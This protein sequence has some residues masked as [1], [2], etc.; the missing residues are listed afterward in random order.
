MTGRSLTPIA[1]HRCEESL[2]EHEPE[3]APNEARRTGCASGLL[4]RTQ[5]GFCWDIGPLPGLDAEVQDFER[6]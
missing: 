1:G 5:A 6:R 3:G 2:A 4:E